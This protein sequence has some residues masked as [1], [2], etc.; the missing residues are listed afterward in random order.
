MEQDCMGNDVADV[1]MSSSVRLF[2][3]KSFFIP[4]SEREQM[5]L[6]TSATSSPKQSCLLEDE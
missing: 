2:P 1:V 4:C 6:T 3:L 5:L